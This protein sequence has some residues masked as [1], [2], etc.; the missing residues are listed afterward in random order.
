MKNH[1]VLISRV[2]D[3]SKSV[4]EVFRCFGLDD[5]RGQS[6][7]VKP[8]ML[9]AA[10]PEECVVTDPRLIEEATRFL[11]SIGAR[12][13]VGDNPMPDP[14]YPHESDVA[15]YCGFTRAAQQKY[16]NIGRFSQKVERCGALLKEFYVS[17]EI[18]DCD[19]LV[20]LPKFKSHELTT[21]TLSV[22][23]HYFQC[24]NLA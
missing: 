12:V 3:L 4:I 8:N 20:S 5:L 15:E 14:R 16:R 22:K 17:R 2:S 18:L 19:R 13:T 9:R 6:V 23:N 7:V 24:I 10:L 11:V 1:R 21:M